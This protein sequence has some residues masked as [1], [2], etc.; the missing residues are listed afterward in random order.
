MYCAAI[1]REH[2]ILIGQMK[3]GEFKEIH[4]CPDLEDFDKLLSMLIVF[5]RNLEL[6]ADKT[7]VPDIFKEAFNGQ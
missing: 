3:I 1:S 7:E 2:G 5:R 4:I 6:F